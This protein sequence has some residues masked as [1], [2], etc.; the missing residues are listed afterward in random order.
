MNNYLKNYVLIGPAYP[1]RGGIS[2]TNHELIRE[3]QKTQK[4][5]LIITFKKLYPKFIFPGKNQFSDEKKPPEIN[6]E[7]HL[8]SYNPISWIKTA[9]RINELNPKTVIF[10]YYTPFLAP[11]YF[12]IT[13]LIKNKIKKIALVDNWIPHESFF[14]D[15]FLNKLFGIKISGFISL[16]KNVS[17][18]IK[19][20]FS[21]PLLTLFHPINQNL[22]LPISKTNARKILKWPKE[23]KIILFYGLIRKYKGLDLL[24]NSINEEPLKKTKIHLVIAGEFYESKEKYLKFITKNK[25]ENKITIYDEYINNEMTRQL[26]CGSDAIIQ[27]Y[28]SSSQ[29]GVTPLA[30]FYNTP[31]LVSNIDGLKD[32]VLKDKSGIV[33]G[34]STKE[35]SQ[36]ILKLLDNLNYYTENIKTVKSNYKWNKFVN[37]LEKFISNL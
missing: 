19:S 11:A 31:V 16:S 32:P 3:I 18:Q 17:N 15:N 34:K 4:N 24:I 6:I 29:S 14:L 13:I 27:T 1:F 37:E 9:K 5:S 21:K 22:P 28:H 30:Y 36:N 2:N 12:F 7:R 33:S 10:R 35:I 20:N 8:S 23:R 25:L 26:F